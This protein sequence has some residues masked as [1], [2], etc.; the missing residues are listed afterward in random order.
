MKDKHMSRRPFV[1]V[2][3]MPTVLLFTVS[4]V[5]AQPAKKVP[6][7]GFL[8]LASPATTKELN[9]A[10]RS[11]LRDLGYVEGQNILIEYRSAE[12]H[13]DRL[14]ELAAELVRLNVDA[15]VTQASPVARVVSKAT[16]SIP[17]INAG[18]GNLLGLIDGLARPGGNITGMSGF[19]SE[20]NPKRLE[21]V[22]EILPKISRVAVLPTSAIRIYG[23]P[24]RRELELKQTAMSM[25]IDLQFL[26][27]QSGGDLPKAF[28]MA[29]KS[30]IE[31]IMLMPD[32]T[33]MYFANIKQIIDLSIKH[34]IPVVG[35]TSRYANAGALMSYEPNEIEVWRRAATYVDKILKG[36]KAGDL[37]VEQPTKFEFVINL[38][39]AKALNLN[40]PQSVLYRAD[41]VIK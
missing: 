6:R 37:P 39:T 12:E 35:T 7:I 19:Y 10:F 5:E 2:W 27:I 13:V 38:K 11:G 15:I 9:A 1:F 32:P 23:K 25:K 31:A 33:G 24:G 18:G 22:K 16:K 20:L 4:L 30:R 21:L 34:R 40:I 36:A 28:A 17:I 41:R 8:D 29:S 14:P 3:L 26:D